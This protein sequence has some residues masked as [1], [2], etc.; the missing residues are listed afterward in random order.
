[1]ERVEILG[2]VYIFGSFGESW[3]M[4]RKMVLIAAVFVCMFV[5]SV[6]S[7]LAAGADAYYGDWA[8][9]RA[10]SGKTDSKEAKAWIGRGIQ[11]SASQVACAKER[12]QNPNFQVTTINSGDF[13]ALWGVSHSKLMLPDSIKMIEVYDGSKLWAGV[14]TFF[15]RSKQ[16]LV[17]NVGGVF[18]ELKKL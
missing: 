17:M 13:G 11:L 4:L 18:F 15:V 12:L 3:Q 9:I 2:M 10:I 7:A 16:T 8:V 5:L 6:S 1:M 14:G